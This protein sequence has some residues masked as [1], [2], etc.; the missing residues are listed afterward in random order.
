MRDVHGQKERFA[1]I[2]F[3]VAGQMFNAKKGRKGAK[4]FSKSKGKCEAKRCFDLPTLGKSKT[5]C[6]LMK[7]PI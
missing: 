4:R 2:F 1:W 5:G 7:P 3:A 6:R